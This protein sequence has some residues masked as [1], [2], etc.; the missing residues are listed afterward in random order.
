MTYRVFVSRTFQKQFHSLEKRLQ[1][2]IR[3]A[4]AT[5][6]DDPYRARSGTDIKK[7]SGTTPSKYRLRVGEYR[8]VYTIDNNV[9]KV[10]ELFKRGRGY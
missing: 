1:R 10:I 4:L 3:S 7:L 6:E 8:V 9:V 5:L 2:R